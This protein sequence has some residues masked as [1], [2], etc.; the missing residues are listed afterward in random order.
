MVFY[1]W[2]LKA[3]VYGGSNLVTKVV[4][5]YSHHMIMTD[6]HCFCGNINSKDADQ[7]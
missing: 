7:F 1:Q 5:V 4:Y 3:T 6:H 2:N